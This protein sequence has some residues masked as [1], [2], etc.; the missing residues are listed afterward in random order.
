MPLI[1]KGKIEGNITML[2]NI[3]IKIVLIFLLIGSIIIGTMG[4]LNYK[5]A[6][7]INELEENTIRRIY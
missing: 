4:Y 6:P 5:G 2:K 1:N 3:Q 7:K